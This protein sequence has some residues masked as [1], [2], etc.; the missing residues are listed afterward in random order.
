MLPYQKQVWDVFNKKESGLNIAGKGMNTIEVVKQFVIKYSQ[1]RKLVFVFGLNEGEKYKIIWASADAGVEFLPKDIEKDTGKKE[2]Q[3]SYSAPNVY[4]H[5]PGILAKDFLQNTVDP[6]IINGIIVYHAEYVHKD[7]GLQMCLAYF[8]SFNPDGFIKAFSER[9]YD[10]TDISHTLELLCVPFVFLSP[11]FEETV[12]QSL[13]DCE[14]QI[15]SI[16]LHNKDSKSASNSQSFS[17]TQLTQSESQETNEKLPKKLEPLKSDQVDDFEPVI[18]D[19][20][21]HSFDLLQSLHKNFIS[22]YGH[23][24]GVSILDSL[25]IPKK[26]L[27]Q[28]A[29]NERKQEILDSLMFFRNAYFVLLH[30]DPSVFTQFLEAKRPNPYNQPLWASYPQ[31]TPL[32]RSAKKLSQSMLPSPKLQWLIH[33]IQLFSKDKKVLVLAEGTA[34]VTMI[35]SYL[36]AFVPKTDS[37]GVENPDQLFDPSHEDEEPVIDPETFGV[38]QPP[39]VMLQEIHAQSDV[40]EIYQPDYVI[41]WDVSLL[42]TRRLEIYNSRSPKK[43][44]AYLLSYPEA[45]E[46]ELIQKTAQTENEIFVSIIQK[47]RTLSLTPFEAFKFSDKHIIVDDREFRSGMPMALLKTGFIVEPSLITVGDYVLSNEIVI[48]RKAFG[49]LVQSLKSGRL[50][51][52]IQRMKQYYSKPMLLIELSDTQF[53]IISARDKSNQTMMKLITIIRYFPTLRIIWGRNCLEASKTLKMLVDGLLE[54]PT[55]EQAQ[56]VG[57]SSDVGSVKDY[58]TRGSRFLSTI[59][60][61]TSEHIAKI[62]DRCKNLKDLMKL[63]RDEMISL[64]GS[65]IGLK[66]FVLLHNKQKIPNQQ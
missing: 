2:R 38:L 58:E 43:V 15:I 45:K 1:E 3:Q 19:D 55:V 56:S 4:F 41:F 59:P 17:S 46:V 49:D 64:L 57:P 6:K 61:L 42:A 7:P 32:F 30:L 44:A 33:L 26:V 21:S 16:S 47:V 11:R 36:A 66:L 52:Q 48:E 10:M 63:K 39:M 27:E 8:K 62:T 53:N 14:M 37:K 54:A 20:L 60:F 28:R 51:Q 65:Q 24:L 25:V 12:K 23:Q 18:S 50:L 13:Q 29:D 9:P 40:F 35:A 5:N 31:V 34:T 22:E